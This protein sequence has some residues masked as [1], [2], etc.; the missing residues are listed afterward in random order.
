MENS[1]A[2]WDACEATLHYNIERWGRPYFDIKPNGRIA[3]KP[4][5]EQD[6]SID[7][8]ELVEQIKGKKLDFP[9][10][11]RFHDILRDRVK[12]INRAFNE[13]ISEFKYRGVYR[14]VFPIKVNQMRE[15]VEEIVDAGKEFHFGLEVGSK[16][17]L[18]AGL[19]MH[20]DNESLIVCNGYKDEEFIRTAMIGRK[21][22]KKIILVIEKIEELYKV[23]EIAE[24]M[25]VLPLIGMRVRLQSKGSGKWATSG[26]EDAKFGLPTADILKGMELLREKGMIEAFQLIHFHVGSQVPDILTIKK[27]VSEATRYYAKIFK[28]GFELKYLDVGGGLGVDYDG[29]RTAAESSTDYTLREYTR[30]I[31]YNILEV[32]EEEEVPHPTIVSESGRAVVA[33]HSVLLV[34]TFGTIEKTGNEIPPILPEDHKLVQELE[35]VF[36]A[37]AAG[38]RRECLHD[39]LQ[40]KEDTYTRFSLGMIDL[41]TK[42]K[43]ETLFWHVA[44]KIV[45]Q[46]SPDDVIPEEV[47]ALTKQLSEQFLCNFSVFQSLID[48]WALGQMF[49]IL[50]ID[51]LDEEPTCEATLV[52]ITCDSDGKISKFIGREGFRQTLRLHRPDG[53]PYLLGFFLMGAYQDV[54]GDIHNLFGSVSEVHVFLDEDEEDGYYIEDVINGCTIDNVLRDVQYEATQLA[55]QMKAQFDLAIKTDRLKPKEGMQLLE[56]YEQGLKGPTYLKLNK[57]P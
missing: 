42:A 44:R 50:P 57:T 10:L 25:K 16:P 2:T 27:A 49:P 30:D 37:I 51:R 32:C 29:T 7:L 34:E 23:V 47:H 48:H 15:V 1:G 4:S 41:K 45:R 3:V 22:E 52:D 36:N 21:L 13:A 31:V 28:E 55:R 38:N 33:H 12:S 40:I 43:I 53:K 9:V 17:E 20:E 18:F 5:Q 6:I 26:G 46:Y 8:V 56:I 24:T 39:A 11:V 35:D 19:A 14:G 54:M